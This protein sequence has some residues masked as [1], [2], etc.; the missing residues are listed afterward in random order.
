MAATASVEKADFVFI[1]LDNSANQILSG[2]AMVK[3]VDGLWGFCGVAYAGKQPAQ[4]YRGSSG[5]KDEADY[6]IAYFIFT[7]AFSGDLDGKVVRI[8]SRDAAF[9][10]IVDIVKTNHPTVDIAVRSCV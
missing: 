5:R 1:D 10:N 6:W 8:I 9:Y 3:D 2:T 7:K 4:T